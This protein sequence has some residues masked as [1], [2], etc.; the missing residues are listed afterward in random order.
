[1]I[2]SSLTDGKQPD[3]VVHTS[4]SSVRFDLYRWSEN[5][6]PVDYFVISYKKTNVSN[7]RGTS[8]ICQ[9][10]FL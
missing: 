7:H 5:H 1:M 4:N 10:T 3:D 8:R 2:V 6:C 9:F